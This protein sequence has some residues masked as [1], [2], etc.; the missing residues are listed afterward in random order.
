[1]PNNISTV[2]PTQIELASPARH[3]AL[4]AIRFHAWVIAFFVRCLMLL[5][6]VV[7]LVGQ[8]RSGKTLILERATPGNILTKT[9]IAAGLPLGR[10]SIDDTKH[11]DLSSLSA[12]VAGAHDRSFAISIQR[13]CDLADLGLDKVQALAGRRRVILTLI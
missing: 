13:L 5:G 7:V 3:R 4:M 12:F 10:F 2:K 11:F 9:T 6:Y 1:M 8:P